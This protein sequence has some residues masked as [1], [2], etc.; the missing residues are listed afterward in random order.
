LSG[1]PRPGRGRS[2]RT[3]SIALRRLAL[4]CSTG[5]LA[6]YLSQR[7]AQGLHPTAGEWAGLCL[8]AALTAATA[9][10]TVRGRDDAPHDPAAVFLV[11][12]AIVLP[13]GLAP[14]VAIPAIVIAAVWTGTKPLLALH[15]IFAAAL[16]AIVAA[17]LAHAVHGRAS[18]AS[19][20]LALAA[21]VAFTAIA[22][23]LSVAYGRLGRRRSDRVPV[24]PGLGTDLILALLGVGL[25]AIWRSEPWLTPVAL[26]PLVLVH[27]SQRLGKLERQAGTDAKTGLMNMHAFGAEL[28]AAV[29]RSR[30]ERR[31]L[32]LVVVDLDFLR[33]INNEHGHLVGDAVIRGIS[34]VLRQEIRR[35]DLAARFGGEEF[36]LALPDTP[37]DRAYRIAERIREAVADRVFQGGPSDASTRATISAGVA[38]FPRDAVATAELIHAADVAVMTAKTRG[39]NRVIDA[40]DLAAA[41]RLA[42]R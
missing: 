38:A 31:P 5:A 40:A 13:V 2:S 14:F 6:V 10:V 7:A 26:L 8:L 41:A 11:A 3:G 30:A 9:F 37:A 16:A 17:Q 23:S 34:D 42:R 1:P 21:A 36:M 22:R 19:A 27:R 25:A 32:A 39:R 35:G 29:A 33:E 28:E 20:L 18:A 4:V 24:M 12:A 15:R